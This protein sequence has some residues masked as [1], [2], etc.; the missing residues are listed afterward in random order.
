MKSTNTANKTS[1]KIAE[2]LL[3][4]GAVLFTRNRPFRFTSGLLSPVY[5]DCRVIISH[6]KER[7]IV[8]NALVEKIKKEIGLPDVVAGIATGG[9]AHAALIADKLN[10]PMVFIRSKPK[11][12]GKGNQVEGVLRRGQKVLIVEDLVSAATSSENA[13]RAVRKLGGVVTDE[14]AIYTHNLKVSDDYFKKAKV[15]FS[16]LTD[17]RQVAKQA[18]KKSFMKKEQVK[19]IEVWVHDPKSWGKKMGFI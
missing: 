5:V 10:L 15:K 3:D 12:H 2:I 7:K 8:A 18:V 14:I 6:P 17:T 1:E 19:I 11:E 4:I 16:Y 9:I 13:V